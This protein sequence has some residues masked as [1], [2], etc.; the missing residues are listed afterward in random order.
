MITLPAGAATELAKR[1]APGLRVHLLDVQRA[2]GSMFFWSDLE[3]QFLS[4]LTGAQQQYK[5]WIKTPP[6]IKR[7]RSLQ[8]DGGDFTLQ[9]LTGNTIDREVAALFKA[10]EFEGAYVIYRR[11]LVPLDVSYYEFHGFI[12]EQS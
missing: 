2:D 6:T 3:G 1:F 11:W 7:T 10:S 12:T 5:P 9:N 4:R 8:A